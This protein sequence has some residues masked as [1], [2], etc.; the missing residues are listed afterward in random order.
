MYTYLLAV[1]VLAACAVLAWYLQSS[2]RA[3]RVLRIARDKS[4]PIDRRLRA[5]RWLIL[6]GWGP[7]GDQ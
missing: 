5:T 4:Q 2:F 3:R 6:R 1:A 7:E